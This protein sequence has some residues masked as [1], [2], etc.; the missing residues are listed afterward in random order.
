MSHV[1]L[2]RPAP[3]PP[4][5]PTDN[6]GISCPTSLRV[7]FDEI[8]YI[9]DAERGVVWEESIIRLPRHARVV[10]LSATVP[11]HLECAEWI[12]RTKRRHVAVVATGHRP[13][14]LVHTVFAADELWQVAD[15]HGASP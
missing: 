4:P 12:G 5:R 11:N 7:I 15:S 10:C 2:E 6:H 14:P 8:H 1:P 13:T 9:N 3:L